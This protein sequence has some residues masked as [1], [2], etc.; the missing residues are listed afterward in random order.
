MYI[1]LSISEVA[2]KFVFWCENFCQTND[3]PTLDEKAALEI[4]TAMA[5]DLVNNRMQWCRQ[6]DTFMDL[7]EHHLEWFKFDCDDRRSKKTRAISDL[8]YTSVIDHVWLTIDSMIGDTVG[9]E[10]WT[11]W[12]IRKIGSDL[13][14]EKGEDYRVVDWERRMASG[15]W[16]N[17]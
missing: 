16:S 13:L 15:E 8:F 1:I 9:S 11:I 17:E 7:I 4:C 3:L 2:N 12:H 14:L 10:T 6:K 5:D